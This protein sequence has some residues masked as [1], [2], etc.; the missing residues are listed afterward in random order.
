MTMSATGS[1]LSNSPERSMLIS[2]AFWREYVT[3]ACMIV[4]TTV[5]IGSGI[6]AGSLL[7]LAF[8]IDSLIE[9]GSAGVLI[10]RLDVE[11]QRGEL[12]AENAE[13]TAARTGAVLLF[14]LASTSSQRPA[15]NC[16]PERVPNFH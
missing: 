6:A 5:A 3:L 8:G 12:F 9:L 13:R 11:L 15:G 14:A 7:L 16:G 4:E 2:Q 1:K 10:W